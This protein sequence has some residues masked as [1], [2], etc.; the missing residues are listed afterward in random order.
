MGIGLPPRDVLVLTRSGG[1]FG[2]VLSFEVE[3]VIICPALRV[4]ERARRLARVVDADTDTVEKAE[5][6]LLCV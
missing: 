4:L 6:V 2:E 5:G 1:R 3:L